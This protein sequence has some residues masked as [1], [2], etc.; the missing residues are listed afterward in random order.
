ML[1]ANLGVGLQAGLPKKEAMAVPALS[2][3]TY[4]LID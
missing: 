4:S 3:D 2:Q 1:S